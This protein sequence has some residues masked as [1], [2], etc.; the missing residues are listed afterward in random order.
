[1]FNFYQDP[2]ERGVLQFSCLSG[3][4]ETKTKQ[5]PIQNEYIQQQWH[6]AASQLQSKPTLSKS[7]IRRRKKL[8]VYRKLQT[9]GFG[10]R[11]HEIAYTTH[12]RT[13]P[14]SSCSDA[15]ERLFMFSW[16][17]VCVC[18]LERERERKRLRARFIPFKFWSVYC[19]F[20][21]AHSFKAD[22]K[23]QETKKTDK[24]K[25]EH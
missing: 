23:W 25:R 4:M 17:Y 1:M 20:T 7:I 9:G 18:E 22:E 15:R 13:F 6:R 19:M 12:L 14:S 11:A 3:G 24:W 16:V 8:Y 2:I 10:N 5:T 21:C